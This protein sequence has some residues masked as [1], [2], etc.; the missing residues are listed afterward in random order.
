MF[1][2]VVARP[3]FDDDNNTQFD[4]KIGIFPFVRE[5]AAQISSKNR[6]DGTLETK[7]CNSITKD[8]YRSYL[9]EKVVPEIR[10]KWPLFSSLTIYV[11]HYVQQDNAR[12]YISVSD[13]EFIQAGTQEGFDIK[14]IC[15]SPN[16]P[17]LNVL[18]LG[19]F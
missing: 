3:R 11:Q 8:I 15:R 4:G 12:P 13:E 18:D 2:V 16:S 17:D 6:V 1:L 9:L 7:A 10:K 19:F 5:E 14:L